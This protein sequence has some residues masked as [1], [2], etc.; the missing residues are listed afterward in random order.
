MCT[1]H[2]TCT[3]CTS[4]HVSIVRMCLTVDF[5]GCLCMCSAG[6][7]VQLVYVFSWYVFSWCMCSAGVCVQ[8]VYVFSWYVFSWC[9]CLAGVRMC[10]AGM[11]LAGVCVQLVCV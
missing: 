5:S 3:H 4:S 11:C 9:M 10:S 6:V 2:V 8:L 1:G 7:C